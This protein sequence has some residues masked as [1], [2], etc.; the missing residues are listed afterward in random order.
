M[1]EKSSCLYPPEQPFSIVCNRTEQW[2]SCEMGTELFIELLFFSSHRLHECVL[3][4]TKPLCQLLITYTHKSRPS[5][6]NSIFRVQTFLVNDNWL[7]VW[8][9]PKI[10]VCWSA[11]R[12]RSHAPDLT[13]YTR[14]QLVW[15]KN[16]FVTTQH[17]PDQSVVHAGHGSS[18]SLYYQALHIFC[19][20][21]IW[22]LQTFFARLYNTHSEV[23]VY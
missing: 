20:E 11:R 15:I 4:T 17:W 13:S 23:S 1:N 21:L 14:F 10:C 6:K 19:T 8:S 5:I 18:G 7:W 22:F 9:S 3:N 12:Q 2:F 16:T